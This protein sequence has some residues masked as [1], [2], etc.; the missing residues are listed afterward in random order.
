VF[1][2]AAS[3]PMF[4]ITMTKTRESP[5]GPQQLMDAGC[6][7]TRIK[8]LG[9]AG[10]DV[11]A[12]GATVQDMR[13]AGW[14]LADLKAAG[15]DAG[16]FIAGGFSVSVLKGAGFTALQLKDAGCTVQQLKAAHFGCE[17]L[18]AAGYDLSLLTAGGYSVSELNG[19]GFTA[20]QL[21]A[22]G[23]SA[24]QLYA[25]EF[26]KMD[27]QDAG[28]HLA[29]LYSIISVQIA[30]PHAL[31]RAKAYYSDI[32]FA[33]QLC[34]EFAA[35]ESSNPALS[36]PLAEAHQMLERIVV[37]NALLQSSPPVC[38][39]QLSKAAAFPHVSPPSACFCLQP[40]MTI[41]FNACSVVDL[42]H[43]LQLAAR[44]ASDSALS[45]DVVARI[46]PCLFDHAHTK[47]VLKQHP[48]VGGG[49]GLVCSA[50]AESKQAWCSMLRD[51]FGNFLGAGISVNYAAQLRVYLVVKQCAKLGR[52]R[53][54]QV[55]SPVAVFPFNVRSDGGFE[56]QCACTQWQGKFQAKT[57]DGEC[58]AVNSVCAKM[59]CGSLES[60]RLLDY[61]QNKQ[62]P[63]R[64][65]A[66][67]LH[68]ALVRFD[69]PLQRLTQQ[70]AVSSAWATHFHVLRGK[71]LYY[72]DGNKGL[73]DSH[74][75]ALA[76]VRS[77]PAPDGRY[78]IDLKGAHARCVTAGFAVHVCNTHAQAAVSRAAVHP[79]TGRRS[80]SRSSSLQ[81]MRCISMRAL[82]CTH[83]TRHL[84]GCKG[85]VPCC[86]R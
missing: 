35:A 82:V 58:C 68:E 53:L 57:E 83:V 78:C 22:E 2:T 18:K 84:A 30:A 42:A 19:A 48:R 69:L 46:M 10:S 70:L 34:G 23:L 43:E 61:Q 67:P 74:E 40:Q 59:R 62:W 52:V 27:L 55:A 12:S 31:A 6:D 20:L 71:R 11:R 44:D 66:W 32:E 7:A 75:G 56:R 36:A 77:N 41:P 47:A 86:R 16:A 13:T 3:Y 81:G 33:M 39:A 4:I 60:L 73:A 51:L 8:A 25:G 9:F 15:F 72:S 29:D 21:K 38:A 80:R 50:A 79:S 45:V 1:D 5:M 54:P 49:S 63:D 28:F 17:E 26:S 24:Q 85:R 65:P 64:Q 37:H 76:F 14:P